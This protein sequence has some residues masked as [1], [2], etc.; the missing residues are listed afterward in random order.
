MKKLHFLEKLMLKTINQTI[1][2]ASKLS[3]NYYSKD[4]PLK[5]LIIGYGG[6]RNVGAE[7]RCA[8][9]IKQI[10]KLLRNTTT[11]I[12]NVVYC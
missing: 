5:I 9:I 8:E 10:K 6:K 12:I 3:Y 4:N 2:K 7:V 11:V 1:F